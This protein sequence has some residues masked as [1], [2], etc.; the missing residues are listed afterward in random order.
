MELNEVVVT[1]NKLNKSRAWLQV[2]SHRTWPEGRQLNHTVLDIWLNCILI[3]D[4]KLRGRKQCDS[5]DEAPGAIFGHVSNY[6]LLKT[7]KW[8]TT[9][10]SSKAA[11]YI[12]L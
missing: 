12:V 3:A 2:V 8:H 7:W 10:Y 9:V 4:T 6:K 11:I 5:G 1:S